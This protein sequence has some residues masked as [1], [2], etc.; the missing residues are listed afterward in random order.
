MPPS[1]LLAAKN[2]GLDALLALLQN[3]A[4]IAITDTVNSLTIIT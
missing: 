1:L 4:Y 2:G 3:G